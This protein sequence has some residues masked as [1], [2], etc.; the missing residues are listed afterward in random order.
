ME[1]VGSFQGGKRFSV[2]PYRS[3]ISIPSF[4][5]ESIVPSEVKTFILFRGGNE[6]LSLNIIK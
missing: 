4:G 1:R 5:N 3:G 2:V 6:G